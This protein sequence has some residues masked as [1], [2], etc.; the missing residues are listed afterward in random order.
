MQAVIRSVPKDSLAALLCTGGNSYAK[1]ADKFGTRLCS[2]MVLV[3]VQYDLCVLC[4]CELS[5]GLM[6][7]RLP[8]AV[9]EGMLLQSR[10]HFAWLTLSPW[11]ICP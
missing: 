9:P 6:D 7:E 11:P 4:V 10:Y 3:I 8:H 5:G 1:V 2:V